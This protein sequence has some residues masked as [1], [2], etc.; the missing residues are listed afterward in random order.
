MSVTACLTVAC[1]DDGS[2]GSSS[3]SNSSSQPTSGQP[4]TGGMLAPVGVVPAAPGG[5]ETEPLIVDDAPP[6]SSPAP[7][8]ECVPVVV[9]LLRDFR[10]SHPNFENALGP[11]RGIV[12]ETLGSDRKPVF[13]G[14]GLSTVSTVDDFNQWYNNTDGV[15]QAIEFTL[16][17][18]EDPT[19]GTAVFEDSTFFPLDDR[20]FGNEGRQHNYHFTFEVHMTFRYDGGEVF[21][22]TG[23]D[24]LF[25]FINDKLAI[26]LGG[27]HTPEDGIAV[28]D[29]M[30]GEFGLIE[31]NE[32]PIDFFHAERHTE[33]SNFRIETSL[34]FT[35]CETILIP[36]MA[37]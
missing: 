28:L 13:A 7:P 12:A 32:Y 37:R 31:G 27:V 33:Q 9:G 17:F 6:R 8:Q 29:E 24:D 14:D 25:V 5:S 10:D 22:F 3:T 30:A 2:A 21:R 26:D 35:N 16:D 18:V 11:E 20:G 4:T 34:A 19:A 15:N 23:D 1:G 36:G